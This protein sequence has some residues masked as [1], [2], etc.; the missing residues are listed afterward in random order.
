MGPVEVSRNIC[1]RL[2]SQSNTPVRLFQYRHIRRSVLALLPN[3]LLLWKEK[4]FWWRGSWRHQRSTRAYW[5]RRCE[6]Y[7]C[8]SIFDLKSR[9][10][11]NWHLGSISP[12]FVRKAKRRRQTAFGKKY[13]I[14]FH[15][16]F[17]LSSSKEHY[18]KI[19][20]ICAPFA[21]FVRHLP[22]AVRQ[23]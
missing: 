1:R 2:T 17:L 16:Q 9:K 12:N 21:K 11:S 15:Q 13:A 10:D 20:H 19:R 8:G 22:N 3:L 23:K 6:A 4:I 14:Q 5:I 18:A 7:N